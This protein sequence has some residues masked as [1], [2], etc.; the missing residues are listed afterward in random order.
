[1]RGDSLGLGR[2]RTQL[3]RPAA[4]PIDH[5]EA[6][7]KEGV[8]EQLKDTIGV[9]P[10]QGKKDSAHRNLFPVRGSFEQD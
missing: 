10:R 6:G 2:R 7:S 8:Q 3:L 9:T 4:L 1:M 5:A